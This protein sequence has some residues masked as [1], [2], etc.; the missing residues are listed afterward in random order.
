[1][2][3]NPF[4]K[5]TDSYEKKNIYIDVREIVT[6]SPQ[7]EGSTGIGTKSDLTIEVKEKTDKV[8]EIISAVL[9]Q[10]N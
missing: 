10:L 9:S 6:I 8:F 3:A 4:A 1:M 7:D 2:A 5:F